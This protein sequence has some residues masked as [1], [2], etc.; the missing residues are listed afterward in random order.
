[1]YTGSLGKAD[2]YQKALLNF[3]VWRKSRERNFFFL[4][5][6]RNSFFK[7]GAADTICEPA[8]PPG[9][10]LE[11]FFFLRERERWK[12]RQKEVVLGADDSIVF[13]IQTWL[14]EKLKQRLAVWVFLGETSARQATFVVAQFALWMTLARSSVLTMMFT[15]F[16]GWQ[17]GGIIEGWRSYLTWVHF[18]LHLLFDRQYL[19][20]KMSFLLRTRQTSADSFTWRISRLNRQWHIW[21]DGPLFGCLFFPDISNSWRKENK[22]AVFIVIRCRNNGRLCFP[23][24]KYLPV[25]TKVIG[26]DLVLPW[27]IPWSFIY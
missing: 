6:T 9:A 23:V 5:E 13:C 22:F 10:H 26:R 2:K 14:T 18:K 27:Q 1:M 15:F 16:F 17:S 25:A 24:W 7:N 21:I 11:M 12:E 19:Y 20:M 8:K 4:P 3:M